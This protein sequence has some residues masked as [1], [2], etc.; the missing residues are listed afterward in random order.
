VG[1]LD[2]AIREHLAL[3][4]RHGASEGELKRKEAEALGPARREPPPSPPQEPSRPG[5]TT[6]RLA[7]AV[8]APPDPVPAT[9]EGAGLFDRTEEEPDLA[10]SRSA[11]PDED[12]ELKAPEFI[13]PRSEQAADR[14]SVEPDEARADL[15][16]TS[17]PDPDLELLPEERDLPPEDRVD[18]AEPPPTVVAGGILADSAPSHRGPILGDEDLVA[19]E[20][21]PST[22]APSESF[23]ETALDEVPLEE[24]LEDERLA[25]MPPDDEPLEPGAPPAADP[26]SQETRELQLDEVE[27]AEPEVEDAVTAPEEPGEESPFL[28]SPEPGVVEEEYI[29]EEEAEPA[30]AA[31]DPDLPPEAGSSPDTAPPEARGASYDEA[32]VYH[33]PPTETGPAAGD[34]LITDDDLL[35]EEEALVA[36][37]EPLEE[38][39]EALDAGAGGHALEEE[40]PYP[41]E[42]LATETGGGPPAEPI[43]PADDDVLEETPEFLQEDSEDERMWFDQGSPRDFDLD[44]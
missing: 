23:E 42:P 35:P 9:E 36:D 21:E 14:P 39:E 20:P 8:S 32:T 40:E 4:R 1:V 24:R 38:E 31:L 18:Q 13:Q 2:D 6:P 16:E 17:A 5:T 34:E 44:R 28:V 15:R 3:K 12:L 30:P 27:E 7:P 33:P 26:A 43:E 19:P 29:L 10:P 25:A 11:A 37:E 41:P 22:P